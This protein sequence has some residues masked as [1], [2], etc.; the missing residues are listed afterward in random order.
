MGRKMTSLLSGIDV[1]ANFAQVLIELFLV[2]KVYQMK[3]PP[4]IVTQTVQ[5]NSRNDFSEHLTLN[6]LP[7]P[8]VPAQFR[9]LPD[10]VRIDRSTIQLGPLIGTG[11]FGIVYKAEMDVGDGKFEPIAVKTLK[12]ELNLEDNTKV[13]SIVCEKVF[14]KFRFNRVKWI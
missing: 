2:L 10:E 11:H 13:L 8:H 4:M 9:T 1:N 5:Y 14:N 12:N 6:P 3:D 7:Q